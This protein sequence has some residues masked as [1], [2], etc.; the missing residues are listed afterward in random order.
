MG[1]MRIEYSMDIISEAV[2]SFGPVDREAKAREKE[3]E[4]IIY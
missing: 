2:R 1:S 3:S 4:G